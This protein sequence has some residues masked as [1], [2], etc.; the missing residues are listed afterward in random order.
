VRAGLVLRHDRTYAFLHDRVQEAAYAL[1]PENRRRE[2]HLKIGR[3][4]LCRF[5]QEALAERVFDIVDQFNRSVELVTD[6]GERETLRRLNTTAGRKARGAAAYA[7][8]HRYLEQ[9]MA[10]LPPDPWNECYAE[11]LALFLELAE[12]EYLVGNFQRA[13]DL[14][15]V[16][17][18]NARSAFDRASG[19]RLRQRLYQLSGRFHDATT[20]AI[21]AYRLLGMSL[22]EADEDILAATAAEIRLVSD[23]L[24]GRSIADLAEVP[25]TDDAETRALV[26]Q[27]ADAHSPI[28][29]VRPELWPLI[30]FALDRNG[31]FTLSEGKGLGDLGLSPGA[32]VGKSILEVYGRNSTIIKHFNKAIAGEDFVAIDEEAGFHYETR[33][34]PIKDDDGKVN[35]AIGVSVDVTERKL[36]EQDVRMLNRELEQLVAERTAELKTAI[37]ELEAFSYSV[38]HDL[39]APLR[40]IDGFLGLL[41]KRSEAALDDQSQRYMETISSAAQRMGLLINDLLSFSR[42]GRGEMSKSQVDLGKLVREVVVELESETKGR[43]IN[44]RIAELPLVTGD[45]AMLRVVLVNLLSNAFKFTQQRERA[46]IEIGSLPS[47]GDEAVVFVRDNGVGFNMHYADK[48]FGVF[49]RLHNSEK[50][51]GTGIGLAN[52]RRVISRHGGRTWAEGRIDEGATFYFTLPQPRRNEAIGQAQ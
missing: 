15:T 52:V 21:E 14:L 29:V 10:L 50:F 36:A 38:S 31:L 11:S 48:L 22:P 8:G 4:L 27:V 28:V 32:V 5:P 13:D 35:G 43:A 40:H 49:Q 20:V 26:G 17:L 19:Y 1:V 9:A 33:W 12:C 23:N 51:E 44:W 30:V 41:R 42:M 46:E 45:C 3:L 47:Q 37:D 2:L 16:A 25:L 6:A 24:R 18:V 39:R 34:T 7:S